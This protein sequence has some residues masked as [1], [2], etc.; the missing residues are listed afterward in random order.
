MTSDRR[1]SDPDQIK[2]E[3]QRKIHHKLTVNDQRLLAR[4]LTQ[5]ICSPSLAQRGTPI[6]L[7]SGA[8]LRTGC[9]L[10]TKYR[11]RQGTF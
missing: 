10:T 1:D 8:L 9:S 7:C 4:L 11:D 3:I 6:T 5:S 2:P